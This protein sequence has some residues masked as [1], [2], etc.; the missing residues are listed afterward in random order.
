MLK[1]FI[2]WVLGPPSERPEFDKSKHELCS[3]CGG[4]GLDFIA[5]PCG[6]CNGNGFIDKR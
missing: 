3:E 5:G 2:D 6:D 4:S 1:K